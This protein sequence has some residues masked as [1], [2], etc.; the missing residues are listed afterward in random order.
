LN[1]SSQQWFE[2]EAGKPNSEFPLCIA[3]ASQTHTPDHEPVEK[4]GT[5]R[6]FQVELTSDHII[7]RV[8][9]SLSETQNEVRRACT[10][11]PLQAA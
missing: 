3:V 2:I 1:T 11:V 5:Q 6:E 9:S 8:S 10:E 7:A 4:V